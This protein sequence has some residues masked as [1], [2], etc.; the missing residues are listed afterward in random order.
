[1][2]MALVK[3]SGLP[4]HISQAALGLVIHPPTA[5]A[6]RDIATTTQPLPGFSIPVHFTPGLPCPSV[7]GSPLDS[8]PRQRAISTPREG[9]SPG[10]LWEPGQGNMLI[11]GCVPTTT[12]TRA[13]LALFI[14]EPGSRFTPSPPGP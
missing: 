1:M 12:T 11:M 13:L 9:L 3:L 14:D 6:Q 7:L 4:G 8:E 5:L 2:Q 10:N